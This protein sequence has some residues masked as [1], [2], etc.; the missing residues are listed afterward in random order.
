M[1][2][3]APSFPRIAAMVVFA[4][5]CFGLLLFLWLS[6][7]GPIPLKPKGYRF[8]VGFK[9][10][11]QLALEADVRSAGVPIGKVRAKHVDPKSNRTIA[12]IEVD[13]KYAP[14]HRDARASLRQKTILGETFVEM[15]MGTKGSPTVPEGGRLD[16]NQ[17]RPS[18][19]LDEI[20]DS[21]DPYTRRAWRTWLQDT[22]EA[23]H[24]RGRDLND[25]LGNL[26]GFVESGGDLLQVLDEQRGALKTL[27]RDTGVVFGALTE[28]E[29]QLE[30]L[31]TA[32]DDVFSAIANEQESWAE[33]FRIFPTFLDE[34]KATFQRLERFSV[35]A[36]P[37]VADLEPAMRDLSPTLRDL[38]TL[39]PD[40][41]R[42]FRNFDP[43]IDVSLRSMPATREVLRGLEPLLAELHPFLSQFN[44]FLNYVGVHSHTLS[45]MFANLGVATAAKVKHPRAGGTGHYLR[46]FG[47]VGPES[48]AIQPTRTSTNR[49]NAYLNPLGVMTNPE[50]PKFK[51]LPSFDCRHIGGEKEPGGT[52]STPGCKVQRSYGPGH[53]PQIREKPYR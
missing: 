9:E 21:L 20:L 37:V 8:E 38:G 39:A 49:G 5:S 13:R 2:K 43:L 3:S 17:V 48:M 46:Q 4:L 27:V 26:P 29:S 47:P 10:A 12:T 33:T 15:T 41:R 42:Y 7:G 24:K 51:I 11:T 32:Q 52:P 1:Q 31:I 28:R 14:I 30:R 53:Y 45:D 6:F 22:G 40:L 36:Q 34:S 19:E 16:D 23:I 25:S 44:P 50:Q 35:K 18:H